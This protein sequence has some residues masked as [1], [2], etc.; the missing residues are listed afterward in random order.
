MKDLDDTDD[1]VIKQQKTFW[2]EKS[3]LQVPRKSVMRP[4]LDNKRGQ[5]DFLGTT[6]ALLFFFMTIVMMV[7]LVPALKIVLNMAQ[8]SDAMNCPG[9]Y[10]M[11]NANHTLSYNATLAAGGDT[12]SIG[13]LAIKMYIPY[14]VLGIL[15]GGVGKI[16][17]GR[18]QQPSQY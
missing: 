4:L 6:V 13:C 2:K 11:G 10:Y 1:F 14:V 8:Q 12:S 16:I 7:A 9:Y 3:N 18:V 17:Y 5:M 15:I